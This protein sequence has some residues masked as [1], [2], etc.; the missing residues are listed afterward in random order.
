MFS[1]NRRCLGSEFL[2]Y[3]QVTMDKL[4]L[5]MS[6]DVTVPTTYQGNSREDDLDDDDDIAFDDEDDDQS[7]VEMI[8][9]N[10]GWVTVRTT[11]VEEQASAVQ[12]I[13]LLAEKLQ[14]H[15]Y[16][17][18]EQTVRLISNLVSSPHEDIRS[19]AIAALPELVRATG[20]A[21]PSNRA[22]LV[23]LSG[24]T[25][26]L[27][28]KSVEVEGALDLIM[29]GLQAIRQIVLY[30]SADWATLIAKTT[31]KQ[32][33]SE[34]TA[35]TSGSTSSGPAGGAASPKPHGACKEGVLSLN[36]PSNDAD[37]PSNAANLGVV[38]GFVRVLDESQMLILVQ[39]VKSILRD[40]LQR[41]AVLHAEAQ[42]NNAGAPQDEDDLDQEQQ[43]FQESLELH[44]NISEVLNALFQTHG[45]AFY[46][47]YM[48][49]WHDMIS[50]LSH[51]FC[52]AEDRRFSFLVI[53]DVIQYG[54]ST[55]TV[56]DSPENKE[57]VT[58]TAEDYL[59]QVLPVLI[60][61][62]NTSNDYELKRTAAY[63]IG[64][65]FEL[66]ACVLTK[67]LGDALQALKTAIT[68]PLADP[69]EVDEYGLCIDNAVAAV[70]IITEQTLIL[71]IEFHQAFLFQQ[72]L[73]CL[74]LKNDLVCFLSISCCI[75][76]PHFTY[77]F[78]VFRI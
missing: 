63:A 59:S 72:W 56:L 68:A 77:S 27:L 75:S 40:S 76:M 3:L 57:G 2:P 22:P 29:T 54:V 30:A 37:S 6:Q 64:I 17:Y 38:A 42:V 20:K 32:A 58:T 70:G 31:A 10:D 4:F 26:G 39:C 48:R 49:E 34:N 28:V 69:E 41:R 66:H 5:A 9:T 8:E 50:N 71:Q 61:C 46:P 7:D 1:F 73:Q 18:V 45:S 53:S 55:H 12:M 36:L 19:F 65:A 25:L 35:S 67:F 16:P 51:P 11:L 43:F 52:L 24:Y 21:M 44:F 62:C 47:I 60:E 78:F 23:E 15:F 13:L 74:P 33:N 14:E